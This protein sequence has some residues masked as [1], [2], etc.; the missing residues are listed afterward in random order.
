METRTWQGLPCLI[1]GLPGKILE[2]TG[3]DA[4]YAFGRLVF[5]SK[6][7]WKDKHTRHHEL[8]HHKQAQADPLFS[9]KY[10]VESALNGYEGN[11]YEV[12]AND[13]ADAALRRN[14]R[15]AARA[16]SSRRSRRRR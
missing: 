6:E 15:R 7:I 13:Y 14:R 2:A 11:A 3:A 1:G 8:A 10:L 16:S 12:E 9:L 5:R 4:C